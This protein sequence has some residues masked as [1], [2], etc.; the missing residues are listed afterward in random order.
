[1]PTDNKEMLYNIKMN[2]FYTLS[3]LAID[4]CLDWEYRM[5][6]MNNIFHALELDL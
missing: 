5:E 6:E 4:N 2:L 1:M 3:H